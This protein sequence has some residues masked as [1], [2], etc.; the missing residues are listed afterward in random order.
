M[1]CSVA[2]ALGN[3]R[4]FGSMKEKLF[5]VLCSLVEPSYWFILVYITGSVGNLIS[6]YVYMLILVPSYLAVAKLYS[7]FSDRRLGA[8]VTT[9]FKS[10]PRLLGSLL[11]I[12]A[13]SMQCIMDSKPEDELD[14]NGYIKRCQNPFPTYFV[15]GFLG[16]SWQLTYIIPPLLP[17]DRILT[18]SVTEVLVVYSLTND[19]EGEVNDFL[20]GVID[21]MKWNFFILALIIVYEQKIKPAI[22]KPSACAAPSSVTHPDSFHFQDSDGLT[23]NSL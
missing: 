11:F 15:S 1:V 10:L 18:W 14:E 5:I 23:I 19:E 21:I 20:G 2:A 22:C 8:A 17:S 13:S 12:S 3:P 16:V 9:I 6:G 4:N 7:K